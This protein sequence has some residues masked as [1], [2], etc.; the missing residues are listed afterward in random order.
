MLRSSADP[1]SAADLSRA[2]VWFSPTFPTGAFGFSH[3]LEWAVEDGDVRDRDSLADWLGSVLRH[4]GGWSDAVLLA[5][6]YRAA[7]GGDEAG[8]RD[9]AELALA[10]QP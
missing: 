9:V 7:E 8:L 2:L 5:A 4:G 10:L 1:A 6:A 3:G